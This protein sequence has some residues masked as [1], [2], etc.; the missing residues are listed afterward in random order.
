MQENAASRI[1]KNTIALSVGRVC[2]MLFSFA[3]V[4]YAARFLGADGFGKYALAMSYFE[5][6]LSLSATGLSIIIT[7]EMAK[8]P[9]WV[10][11]YLSASVVLVTILMAVTGGILVIL[12]HVSGYAPD[13]RASLHLA[14][15]ALPPAT[16]SLL[17]EA[18]F[19]AF[20]KAKYVTYGTVLENVLRTG[21]GLLALSRGYGL[22]ALFLIL[23]I[24]RICMWCFYLYFLDRRVSKLQWCFDSVLFR[25]LIRDLKVFGLENWLSN[26]FLRLDVVILSFFCGEAMVGLYAAAHKTLRLGAVVAVSYASAVFPYMSRLFQESRDAFERLSEG[27]LKYMFALILPAV[28]TIAVLA[29]RIVL[30]LYTDKYAGSIPILRVLA[31]VLVPAFLNPFMSHV[32]F[33]RGEQ[34]RSLQVAAI[35]L[36]CHLALSLWFVPRWG[37][38]GAAWALLTATATASCF[39]L[40]FLLMRDGARR[41]LSVFARTALAAASFGALLLALRGVHLVPLLACAGA[42]Y[43]VVLLVL[44][45]PLCSD[46]DLLGR[47]R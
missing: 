1:T 21:L 20:Q 28:V 18:A 5:L 23:I 42:L 43:V 7:R 12:S 38:I 10:M 35:S 31:W 37:A 25:Q 19:V 32:L 4:V 17:L 44:R 33:A 40:G 3:F 47:L 29:D 11:R 13:M 8:T 34:E 27:S 9:S 14:C 26:L 2:A 16:I 6:V 39:Y 24:A 36:V 46:L 45:V 15:V 22:P 30:L 41:T